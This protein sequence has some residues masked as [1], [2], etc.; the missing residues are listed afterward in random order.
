MLNTL[1]TDLDR[2]H[3]ERDS[4]QQHAKVLAE[5]AERYHQ[6]SKRLDFLIRKGVL[7][8][9]FNGAYYVTC[10]VGKRFAAFEGGND[11]RLAIDLAMSACGE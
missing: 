5:E 7:H 8:T 1:K 6:D 4:F 10:L 11:A 3:R 2:L 9:D